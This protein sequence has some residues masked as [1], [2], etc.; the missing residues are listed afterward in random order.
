MPIG[1]TIARTAVTLLASLVAASAA[2]AQVEI[3][4]FETFP[5]SAPD[6]TLPYPGGSVIC[7]ATAAGTPTGFSL[8]FGDPAQRA[9]FCPGNPDR[10][11]PN[12]SFGARVTGFLVAPAAGTYDLTINADDGDRLTVNGIIQRTD[13]FNKGG[14][15]GLVGGLDLVAGVN[16]FTFDYYQGP[17]C[18]AFIELRTGAGITVT[19]P[20]TAPEPGTWA[21]M[22]TGLVG[23]A[24]VAR[25]RR[26]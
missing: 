5:A 9:L 7:T 23:V 11:S 13:W 6:P 24:G 4:F 18:G 16:P 10:I 3:T 1:R 15:P 17:C 19:P 2:G 20:T 12:F 14:G 25:R 26:A 8:N 22:A 21:L